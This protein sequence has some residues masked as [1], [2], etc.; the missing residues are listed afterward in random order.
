MAI[1]GGAL[2]P[3]LSGKVAD[4]AGLAVALAVPCVCYALIAAYGWSARRAA[5]PLA[6][7]PEAAPSI[8]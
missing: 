1:V 8:L 5:I 2:I 7:P 6:G 3:V 4:A